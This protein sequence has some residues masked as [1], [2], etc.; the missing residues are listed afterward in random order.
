LINAL[1]Q[2]KEPKEKLFAGSPDF[3][4]G[5]SVSHPD[6]GNG[7]VIAKNDSIVT[8]AFKKVGVK[9]LALGVAVL[10]KL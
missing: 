9:K 8:V 4:P 10:N 2:K 6:F 1:T 3:R 7:L 5:D